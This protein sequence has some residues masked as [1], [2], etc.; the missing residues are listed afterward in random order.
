MLILASLLLVLVV[1]AIIL[2]FI[3]MNIDDDELQ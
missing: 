2:A 1:F 3:P